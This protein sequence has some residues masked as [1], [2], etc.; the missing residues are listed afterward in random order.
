MNISF[1]ARHERRQR[2]LRTRVCDN[3][4]K[5]GFHGTLVSQGPRCEPATLTL[6]SAGKTCG[7]SVEQ[8]WQCRHGYVSFVSKVCSRSHTFLTIASTC[9]I[10]KFP[11]ISWQNAQCMSGSRDLFRGALV[12]YN[13]GILKTIGFRGGIFFRFGL[14]PVGILKII[15]F[16]QRDLFRGRLNLYY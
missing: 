6:G 2:P 16:F 12:K 4:R 15:G 5:L 3:G 1:A 10:Q 9:V 11:G 8:H 14:Q 13:T 7:C